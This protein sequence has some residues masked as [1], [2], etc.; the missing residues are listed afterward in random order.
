M[1]FQSQA[2]LCIAGIVACFLA[3]CSWLGS[4][5]TP[6]EQILS[7]FKDGKQDESVQK[8]IDSDWHLSPA[9]GKNS[10]MNAREADFAS[11]TAEKRDQIVKGVLEHTNLIRSLA[12]AVSDKSNSIVKSDPKQAQKG[13]AMLKELGKKMD[14]PEGLKIIQLIGQA[15]GKLGN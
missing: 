12:K 1:R 3:G 7:N 2:V 13:K 9:F 6:L 4:S 5:K 11:L 10:P 14:Q 15:V 8:F